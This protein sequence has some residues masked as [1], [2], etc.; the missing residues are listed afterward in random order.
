M[1]KKSFLIIFSIALLSG[2]RMYGQ[3]KSYY[4]SATG[5]DSNDGL[6]A[7]SAWRTIEKINSYDFKPGDS[8]F[9]EGGSRFAGTIKLSSDDNGSVE[10]PVVLISFGKGKAIVDA[11]EGEGLLAVNT[12]F[13][14]IV[15]LIFE[16]SGVNT[17]KGSGIHFFANDSLRAPK[18]VEIT[19][20]ETRGF[21]HYGI[22]IGA[23][24][25][26]SWKG[27]DNVRITHSNASENGN[28]GISSYGSQLGFQHRNF[29]VAYSRAFRNRGIISKTEGHTG[30]GIVMAMIDGLVIEHCEA[31]ENGADNRCTA[32]GPVGI[33]V[34][35]CRNAIIQYCVSRDN[36]AGATKD[37][38]G[39]DIDG[40]SSNC[41]LQFN[42]SYNNEGAGYL[43]A[44]FGALFPFTN[45]IIRF[46][47]SVNDGRKNGYGGITIWGA[48][49]EF[50]VTNT[51]VY[52]NSIYVD[53]SKIV[54]GKPAGITLL[55][56]HFKNVIL[57]N[58]I[59]VTKGDVNL[60]SADTTVG[61][62]AFRLVN[63]QY[64][65]KSNTYPV[66]WGRKK[67]NNVVGWLKENPGQQLKLIPQ[68]LQPK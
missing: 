44:E 18:N 57:A 5:K 38:G 60:I 6:S 3:S 17:N 47:S 39:F 21:S 12:S 63:N 48:A 16:G 42:N 14:K 46:N 59:I 55:G 37:G 31:F 28:G 34:W 7:S 43:L 35:M 50:Q 67:Y 23:N 66:Q 29:Y 15:S 20:C 10:K 52:N 25:D 62:S 13:I 45:N 64:Y 58:N 36:F 27:Y 9:L 30:N 53:D 40:G 22:V 56:P 1:K 2:G 11:G 4:V 8:L 54:D 41:I 65:S 49:A 68:E 19:G 26:S 61:V 51:Q 32:G 24:A 33:W